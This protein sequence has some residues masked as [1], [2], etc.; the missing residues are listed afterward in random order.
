MLVNASSIKYCNSLKVSV[1]LW[2]WTP[3]NEFP[4]IFT[5]LTPLAGL[6]PLYLPQVSSWGSTSVSCWP[7]RWGGDVQ[8]IA[9]CTKEVLRN[10]HS[11]SALQSQIKSLPGTIPKSQS[12]W[13]KQQQPQMLLVI[14]A[15]A[16]EWSDTLY[17]VPIFIPTSIIP[18][19]HKVECKYGLGCEARCVKDVMLMI[20]DV[21]TYIHTY[22]ARTN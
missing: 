4:N 15:Y 21:H 22:L 3:L 5:L 20:A 6:S 18:Y 13:K 2:T 19:K 7:A 9:V 17:L 11:Q 10:C 12:L 16:T 14:H 8:V 1:N